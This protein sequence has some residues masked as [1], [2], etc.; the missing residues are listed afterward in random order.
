VEISSFD[1]EFFGIYGPEAS[2]VPPSARFVLKTAF[3]A[4]RDANIPSSKIKGSDMAVYITSSDDGYKELYV[5]LS[6]C[7]FL[8]LPSR[9]DVASQKHKVD[10]SPNSLTRQGNA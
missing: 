8:A 6:Q 4:L 5:M 10:S 9:G 2:G 7:Y 1:N 3:D